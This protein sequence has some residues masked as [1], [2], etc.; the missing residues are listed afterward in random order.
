MNNLVTLKNEGLFSVRL[1]S[2][3][4]GI[5]LIPI[6]QHIS[7]SEIA[8]SAL[9]KAHAVRSP[10]QRKTF[11]LTH[12][13]VHPVAAVEVELSLFA[14]EEEV[15]EVL[16]ACDELGIALIAYSYVLAMVCAHVH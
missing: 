15:K 3:F 4:P 1:R 6:E 5:P 9:R 7:L 16:E 14:L 2:R 10:H 12:R 13:Q 11:E 8:A